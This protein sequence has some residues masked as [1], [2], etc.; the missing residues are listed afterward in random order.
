MSVKGTDRFYFM[1]LQNLIQFLS[2]LVVEVEVLALGDCFRAHH[3][4]NGGP[5]SAI[6]EQTYGVKVREGTFSLY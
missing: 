1:L 3:L 4:G 2:L 6:L 5:V